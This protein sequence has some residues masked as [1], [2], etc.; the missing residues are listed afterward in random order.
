MNNA[1][2]NTS[3][4][5]NL[6]LSD[7]E[8]LTKKQL[9]ELLGDVTLEKK[10][11]DDLLL[12]V[13]KQISSDFQIRKLYKVYAE[14]LALYPYDL[15][16]ILNITKSER[17]R[18]TEEE[19]LPV[20]HQQVMYKWGK[21]IHV[22]MYDRYAIHQ[23]TPEKLKKWRKEQEE[24]KKQRKKIGV[25]KTKITKNKNEQM[26]EEFK[27][28]WRN[29]LISWHKEDPHLAA[30]L[31]LA[32][33]TLWI[34]R[35]AKENQ[36][37]Q[38]KAIKEETFEGYKHQ[39]EVLYQHKNKAIELLKQSPYAKTT[40]YRPAERADKIFVYFCSAHY[41]DWVDK[42]EQMYD[43]YSKWDFL[44][45]HREDIITCGECH[46]EADKDFYSLYHLEIADKWEMDYHF[47]FHTPYPIGISFFPSPE[48]L[49][50]VK[51]Q[52]QEGIFRFGRPL[53]GEE[54]IIHAEKRV[55]KEFHEA[56]VKYKLYL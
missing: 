31:N 55:L 44:H 7:L 12:E 26:R 50:F 53:F 38:M 52:E 3:I 14:Q 9:A 43:F 28:E 25:K 40:F 42:R 36:M 21:H 19:R 5:K 13:K 17:K 6:F 49:E 16:K 2:T 32:F 22:P 4:A 27:K 54:K 30:T 20:V 18:W 10:K 23:I 45:D 29:K 35:W 33:W 48:K 51:H 8:I 56:V 39:K 1:K 34:S 37:K 24:N 41:R 47:S 15:E 46:Y 11:K